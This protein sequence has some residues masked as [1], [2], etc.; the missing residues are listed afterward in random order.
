MTGVVVVVVLVL[1]V[2]VV[3]LARRGAAGVTGRIDAALGALEVRRQD[4]AT[5]NGA[6]GV[7]VLTPDELVFL[8]FVPDEQTR[9]PRSSITA[10]AAEADGASPVLVVSGPDGD[11]TFSVPDPDGWRSALA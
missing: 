1:V 10:V 3:V 6:R 2:V 9:L 4:K 5:H 7:L 8:Q 11:L